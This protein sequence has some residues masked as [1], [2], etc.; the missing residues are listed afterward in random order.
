M[1]RAM[2]NIR[3][4]RGCDVESEPQGTSTIADLFPGIVQ[5]SV[6]RMVHQLKLPK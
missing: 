2:A 4:R 1:R 6:L 3:A 5:I